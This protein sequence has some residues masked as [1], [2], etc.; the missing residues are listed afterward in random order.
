MDETGHRPTETDGA[1]RATSDELIAALLD[2]QETE[3]KKR[4]VPTDSAEFVRLAIVADEAGKMVA[5]WTAAQLEAASQAAR[6]VRQGVMTGTPIEQVPPRPLAK[7][8]AQWREAEHRLAAAQP[9]S[10]EG[11]VAAADVR[12]FQDEYQDASRRKATGEP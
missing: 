7:I 5:R 8:L 11:Q 1:A 3:T 4:A 10:S 6:L 2:L 9:G 12:R